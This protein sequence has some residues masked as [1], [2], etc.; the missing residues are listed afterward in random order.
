MQD[1]EQR[2]PLPTMHPDVQHVLENFAPG[3]FALLD[4]ELAPLAMMRFM[5]LQM[6]PYQAYADT[7][8]RWIMQAWRNKLA[9][10]EQARKKGDIR[11]WFAK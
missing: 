11:D 1:I 9:R 7:D 6:M 5:R 8:A 3:D 2:Q 4:M 10:D